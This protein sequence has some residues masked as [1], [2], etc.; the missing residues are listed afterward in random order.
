MNDS[1]TRQEHETVHG[2]AQFWQMQLDLAD[3][4]DEA[5]HKEGDEVVDRYRS[6]STNKA[7]GREKKFNILWSNT[8]TLKGALFARMAK[9]DVRRRF[10][11]RDPVG[12]QVSTVVERAVEYTNDT[13]DAEGMVA[14][15][16]ED[17]LLPGRGVVWVVYEP[18]IIAEDGVE[19]VGRQECRD[20][21]VNWKDYRESPAKRPEEVWW[22]ARRHLKTRD[23]LVDE[24]PKHGDKAPLNWSPD[25]EAEKVFDD[26]FKRAEVWEIWDATKRQ[27]VY[28][29]K[30]YHHVLKEEDDPYGLEKFF[31]CPDALVSVRTNNKNTPVPEFRLYKD[32]ADELDRITT[33]INRLVEALKR[34][35]MYDASIPELAKLANAGDNEFVPTRN[36]ASLV[37]SGGLQAA[38]QS[39]DITTVAQAILGL[40]QQRDMLVQTIY[41]ITGISDIIRGATDPN[42]TLGAQKL[43]GQFGSMRMK[44]R[45]DAVQK[46]IRSLFRIKAELMA[47]HYEPH[48]L[49]K[50]T[51]IKG[52][53]P[54]KKQQAMMMA[55]QAQGQPLPPE[56]QDILND[57]TW[58][59]MMAVMRDDKMR[60]Y[61]IDIETDSTVF[62]DAEGEKQARVEFVNTLGGFLEKALPVVQ[63]APEMT[64]MVFEAM[65]FMVRGFKIGRSFED[66]IDETK[67]DVLSKQKQA[68]SQPPQPDPA[69]IE[70]EQKAKAKQAEMQMQ[71]Q[72]KQAQMQQDGQIKAQQMKQDNALKWAAQESDAELEIRKQDIEAELT[73]RRDRMNAEARTVQ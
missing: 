27:R 9:P 49:E 28:V 7:I 18:T 34:R 58:D 47:E 43:K 6:E 29:V 46:F 69:M 62:E 8:E 63:S 66:V 55:Q 17:Y 30:G 36:Y 53:D 42:E 23:E 45:Q 24:F 11:D 68:Q 15:A 31:P 4:A 21:Y 19:V 16:I 37:Q 20:E 60:S 38:M 71:G 61:R 12:R 3:K 32:Q 14:A 65:D 56:V 35:G 40:Y 5:W 10:S 48:I 70:A 51:G 39:E 22:K 41:E 59:E 2:S 1:E 72:M 44:K 13:T 57:P 64:G 33:R 67:Q 73:A 54:R 50:M 26:A 52:A 25:A